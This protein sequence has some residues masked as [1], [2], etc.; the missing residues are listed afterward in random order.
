MSLQLLPSDH[1]QETQNRQ[2]MFYRVHFNALKHSSRGWARNR[3]KKKIPKLPGLDRQ[4][5]RPR[6][7]EPLTPY[8]KEIMSW[9]NF[10]P[11]KSNKEVFIQAQIK[12]ESLR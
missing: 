4:V 11:T 3:N 5:T 12:P 2:A 10:N 8:Q 6:L 1:R 9:V 7:N